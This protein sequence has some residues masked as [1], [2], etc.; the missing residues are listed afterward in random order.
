MI[1]KTDCKHYAGDRPCKPAKLEGIKCNDCKYYEPVKF[2]ILIIK[3]DAVGDVLRTTS[4]LHALKKK[5]PQSHISWF[6]KQNSAPIFLNNHLVDSLL[7][8]EKNET[9]VRLQTEKFDLLIHPDASPTSSAFASIIK[10]KVKKGFVLN[11]N[12]KVVPVD[13]KAIEW[14]EMGCFDDI[15]KLNTKTYQQILHE[16]VGLNYEKDEI[17]INLTDNE[18][19]FAKTFSE[20]NDLKKFKRIIG[21]NTGAS[22]RWQFKQWRL[23]GFRDLIKLLSRDKN[24]GILIYGGQEEKERNRLLLEEFPFLIDTGTDNTLRQFF[25]LV[26]LSDVFIT[27]DTLALHTATA[28]KK[29]VICFF[30]PTSHNEIEDYGRIIKVIPDIS[31]L[32]CYKEKCDFKPNCMELIKAEEIYKLI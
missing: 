10:S 9:L 1:L 16:I 22:D 24:I 17:I 7:I 27:G 18:L 28:L 19:E 13:R 30:G 12:G 4:I 14:L 2:K 15:K 21:L 20:K 25:A 31:C 8:Y 5:Y 11:Q 26:N 32:I 23:D 3:F 29:K 6:T